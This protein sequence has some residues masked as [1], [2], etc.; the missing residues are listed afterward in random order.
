MGEAKRR[1]IEYA[2]QSEAKLTSQMT[3]PQRVTDA[4]AKGLDGFWAL[5][6][7]VRQNPSILQ[8]ATGAWSSWCYVP[9]NAVVGLVAHLLNGQV[10]LGEI[11]Q[12]LSQK[13][14]L[15]T[16]V[17]AW[18]MAKSVYVFDPDIARALSE[19]DAEED[20][21]DELFLRLP[22]W[23]PYL[24]TPTLEISN[25]FHIH[26]FFSYVDDR[27]FGNRHHFP[28]ELNFEILVDTELSSDGVLLALGSV[29]VDIHHQL[30]CEVE[31]GNLA[32]CDVQARTIELAR[33]R[34]YLHYHLNVPLGR[35]A[36]GKACLE[37]VGAVRGSMSELLT[38]GRAE[39]ISRLGGQLQARL[40]ALLLYL[41]SE[42]PDVSPEMG[43]GELRSKI[44]ANERRA[45][46]NYQARRINTW[47]VGYRVGAAL[48]AFE[49]KRRD[50]NDASGTG[51]S[52]RPHVRRAHW[53]SFWSGPRDRAQDR[54]KRVRWLPPIPVNVVDSN[55]LVPTMHKVMNDDGALGCRAP[56]EP[57]QCQRCVKRRKG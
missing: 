25:G 43:Q 53:H 49:V 12:S 37:Q 29:D 56:E 15:L 18:R 51:A 30:V 44:V 9:V 2:Q 7:H 27:A 6:E 16:A 46:R 38:D 10:T 50:A 47:E 22:D 41:V 19:S 23:C 33:A 14:R 4:A 24:S 34:E 17:S 48:R 40:G 45:I 20:L 13:T 32:S 42:A 26:G 21:P 35:G 36:F 5:V 3:L 54:K 1:R 31:Q 8:G 57:C 52:M 55:S 11:E 28:P 39:E